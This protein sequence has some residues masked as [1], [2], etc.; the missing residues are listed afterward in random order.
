MLTL[1]EIIINH[2]INRNVT[3]KS[4]LLPNEINRDIFLKQIHKECGNA[5]NI[6]INENNIA[7]ADILC[8]EAAFL[9]T[10]CINYVLLSKYCVYYK[11]YV[12]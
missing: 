5:A 3:Y 9:E 4:W 12:I 10:K 2:I 8:L 1:Y 6:I 11:N 7:D